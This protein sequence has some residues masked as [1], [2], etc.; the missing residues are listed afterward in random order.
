M[1]L[2]ASDVFQADER[3]PDRR[4]SAPA[5]LARWSSASA[6]E[7][8]TVLRVVQDHV[9]LRS[10]EHDLARSRPIIASRA[11]K[12]HERCTRPQTATCAIRLSQS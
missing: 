8:R 4:K 5:A 6:H 9:L 1:A 3:V 7:C 10:F 11:E 12:M 2:S